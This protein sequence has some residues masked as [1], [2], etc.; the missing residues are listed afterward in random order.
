MP[1]YITSGALKWVRTVFRQTNLK[2][3]ANTKLNTNHHYI[4]RHQPPAMKI[5]PWRPSVL[6]PEL[7]PIVGRCKMPF[8]SA[9]GSTGNST[10]CAVLLK[11]R[12]AQ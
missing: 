11:S 6:K 3:R 8:A 7:S 2:T 10:L 9:I 12:N 5:H 4:E 1:P